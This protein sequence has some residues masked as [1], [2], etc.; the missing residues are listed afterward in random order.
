MSICIHVSKNKNTIEIINGFLTVILMIRVIQY[1]IPLAKC[2]TGFMRTVKNCPG[3][4]LSETTIPSE[5]LCLQCVP[6]DMNR[7]I[8]D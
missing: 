6:I 7:V 2:R 1:S 3:T 4:P 8:K 5:G